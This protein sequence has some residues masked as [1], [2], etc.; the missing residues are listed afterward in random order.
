MAKKNLTEFELNKDGNPFLNRAL[1]QIA[2]AIVEK[3]VVAANRDEGAIL[4]GITPDGELSGEAIFAR[5]VVKDGRGFTKMFN[6]GFTALYDLKPASI[7]VLHFIMNHMKPNRDDV[8]ILPEE[9][10]KETGIKAKSTIYA[11]LGELCAAEV[12]ARGSFDV[13]YY[14]NPMVMFNGDTITFSLT[15]VNGDKRFH[16]DGD[17]EVKASGLKSTI[18]LLQDE[19]VLPKNLD[20]DPRQLH[21]DMDGEDGQSI[22]LR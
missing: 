2:N 1:P 18:K 10:M 11:A 21:L 13:Q 4:R 20:E 14:I 9:V 12:I 6:W 5:R 17:E 3:R 7:K 22:E 16:K 15:V 19:G 8:I